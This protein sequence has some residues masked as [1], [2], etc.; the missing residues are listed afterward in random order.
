M[1]QIFTTILFAI[2]LI[3]NTQAQTPVAY[4]PFNGNANDAAGT[5]HGTVNGATLTTD[6]FGNANSAYSF[7]GVSNHIL[8]PNST[9]LQSPATTQA[10]TQMCW[11]KITGMPGGF[12]PLIVKSNSSSSGFMYRMYAL[13][14]SLVQSIN[15][16]NSAGNTKSAAFNFTNNIWYQ[17]ATTYDGSNMKFYVNGNLIGTQALS[18][19]INSDALPL[20]IGADFPGAAEFFQGS[21]DEVKI[22]N[23]PL[24]AA[25][26]QEEYFLTNHI[27]KPGS[28]NAL[29]FD[30]VND[31]VD[32]GNTFTYQNFT[33]DMWVNPATFQPGSFSDLID[34]NHTGFHSWVCQ[35]NG[36][37]N[38]DYVFGVHSGSGSI[39]SVFFSLI[40][41]KWQ[42]LT[43]VKSATSVEVYINGILIQSVASSGTINYSSPHLYLGAW[44]G[45]GRHWNGQV[46]EVRFWNSP[47]TQAQIRDRMCRKITASDALYSNLVAY[48]N[49]D[50]ST[51]NTAFDASANANNGT[52]QNAPTSVTSGAAIGNASSHDYVNATKNTSLSHTTGESFTVTNTT[53]NPDGLQVYMVNEQPNTLN[54]AMGVGINNKYFGVFQVNGTTPTYQAVYNYSG[55]GGVNAGN[56][57]A[58]ALFKRNDNASTSWANAVATLNTTAK[59]LT[60]SGQSTEYMLGSTGAVLPVTLLSFYGNLQNNN[61]LL[62]WQTTNEVNTQHFEIERS[63]NGINFEKIGNVNANNRAGNNGYNF[64]DANLQS[65][66]YYYRLKMMDNNG[67][68][69]YSNIIKLTS[70]HLPLTISVF[71]NPATD[72]VTVSGLQGNGSL[73]I[74]SIEGKILQ[75]LKVT[76]QSQTIDVSKYSSG[77][78]SLKYINNK[79]VVQQNL[80]IV[81]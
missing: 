4:Y 77:M 42:H 31:Y 38:N 6:R 18:V 10:Y 36:T 7:D 67:T 41:N 35:T 16:Y 76:A 3:A 40:P 63:Q 37:T 28:G 53:G 23:T 74:I 2:L 51:G 24:T 1:K 79:E 65:T 64:T 71:P 21:I 57:S 59:T 80:I 32:G 5:N 69:K 56:E 12:A 8:I 58:L 81:K 34:N 50:E 44:G 78:Y 75:K 30:G 70:T 14:N 72:V 15:D 48:Y 45:G 9:S 22:Y 55:N 52:L 43:F 68:F 47:L 33:I 54:G 11:I 61:A 39:G 27:F 46:D 26:V 17:V 73:K 49:F 60:C 25:Q 29:S 13:S 62:Q 20:V 19:P 66:V